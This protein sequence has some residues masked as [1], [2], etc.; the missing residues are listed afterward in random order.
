MKVLWSQLQPDQLSPFS[1]W[2]KEYD[3]PRMRVKTPEPPSPRQQYLAIRSSERR[4]GIPG[5]VDVGEMHERRAFPLGKGFFASPRANGNAYESSAQ[6]QFRARFSQPG[7][8]IGTGT[9]AA[10]NMGSPMGSQA[11]AQSQAYGGQYS[12]QSSGYTSPRAGSENQ[13][14]VA[15]SPR[16]GGFGE[17]GREAAYSPRS[18]HAYEP[19]HEASRAKRE[20]QYEAAPVDP[21]GP[22]RESY[23]GA[24]LTQDEYMAVERALNARFADMRKAFQYVDLD[25]S[26][27]L[28]RA[29]IDRALQMWGVPMEPAKLDALMAMCDTTGEGEISY[30]EFCHALARDKALRSTLANQEGKKRKKLSRSAQSATDVHNEAREALNQRFADL[31]KAFQ[32]VD[33]D[34]SG[35]LDRFEVERALQLW[36]VNISGDKLDQLWD[37]LDTNGNGEISYAEFVNALARDTAATMVQPAG[38]SAPQLSKE[39]KEIKKTLQEAEDAFSAKFSDMRKAFK[40]VDLDN[41]GTVD[42]GE[43]ENALKMWNIRLTPEALE[44]LWNELDYN[45]NGEI[46]YHE[47]VDAMKRDA[48]SRRWAD[49][50]VGP[51]DIQQE[52]PPTPPPP[53]PPRMPT[54]REMRIEEKMASR[55]RF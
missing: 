38:P 18:Q 20:Q 8:G 47:F 40:Y 21:E 31:H 3:D 16:Q 55:R 4:Q 53:P 23:A 33:L 43:L 54:L 50:A 17:P 39:Q 35:T 36:G 30:E 46:S 5:Y 11:Y 41:S 42:R 45:G 15:Y 52:K 7:T 2:R 44:R 25:G 9:G 29:E 28:D 12:A 6:A 32:T 34:R 51:A 37:I 1:H 48:V 22:E 13:Q 19:H 24:M 27:T 26:G 14:P 10:P 49:K